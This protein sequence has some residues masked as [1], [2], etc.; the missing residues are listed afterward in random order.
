MTNLFLDCGTNL[1]QGLMQFNKMY[2][3][4]NN[5]EWDIYTFEP[6]PHIELEVMFNDVSNLKKIQ[7]AVWV[8]DTQLEFLCKGK[9][10]EVERMKYNEERFQGGGS[11]ITTTNYQKTQ[12]SNIEMR[13]V[14]VDALNFSNFLLDNQDKYDKIVVKFD[15]EGAEFQIIDKLVQDD[16]LKHID[17]LFMEPHGRFFFQK[18]EWENKKEEISQIEKELFDKCKSHTNVH[19]WS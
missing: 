16:T 14:K 7:K 4:F 2:N 9:K 18:N 8:E 19:L 15:I 1:G 17:T 6:N 10:D 11:Q 12:P 3:L 13:N 5:S